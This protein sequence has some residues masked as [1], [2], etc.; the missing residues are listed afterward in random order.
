MAAAQKNVLYIVYDDL[1]PDLRYAEALW[2]RP[3][4]SS[5]GRSGARPASRLRQPGSPPSLLACPRPRGPVKRECARARDRDRD[6]ERHVGVGEAE[7][8]RA[9]NDEVCPPIRCA[10]PITTSSHPPIHITTPCP[11]QRD[12]RVLN[13][14]HQHH[15]SPQIPFIDLLPSAKKRHPKLIRPTTSTAS[16]GARGQ[17]TCALLENPRQKNKELSFAHGHV[18][19]LRSAR[20]PPPCLRPPPL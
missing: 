16:K 9:A 20:P 6:R 4:P 13:R 14:T 5:L 3:P 15:M 12:V 11:L 17:G 8:E 2:P 1:R 19:A 18:V 10:S 7:R